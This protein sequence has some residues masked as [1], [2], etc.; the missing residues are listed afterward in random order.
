[1]PE[2]NRKLM[3]AV[4]AHLL[5]AL[6]PRPSD[7]REQQAEQGDGGVRVTHATIRDAEDELH[8][9]CRFSD[10][11][12]Y[13]AIRLDDDEIGN[14]LARV[15]LAAL[16]QP[17]RQSEDGRWIS[18]KK[19]LP[20]ADDSYALVVD[21]YSD[22]RG[23]QRHE[24]AMWST[25]VFSDAPAWITRGGDEVPRVTHWMPLPEPPAPA[26]KGEERGR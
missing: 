3:V 23:G 24:L 16:A 22:V 8:I 14:A 2:K 21:D 4:C 6:S 18:V 9:E 7:V 5:A 10:G 1:V 11:Q 17:P 20:A 12:K 13:A 25:R 26:A 15:I 19:R